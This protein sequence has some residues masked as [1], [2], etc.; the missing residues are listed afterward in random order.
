M[1]K[2]PLQVLMPSSKHYSI[3]ENIGCGEKTNIRKASK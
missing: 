3:W 2:V 1:V